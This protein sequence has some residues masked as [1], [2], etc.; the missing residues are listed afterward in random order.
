MS[1]SLHHR[2]TIVARVKG[3]VAVSPAPTFRSPPTQI[4]YTTKRL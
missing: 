3:Y 4:D 2:C 1:L